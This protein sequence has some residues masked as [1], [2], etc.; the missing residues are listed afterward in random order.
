MDQLHEIRKLVERHG[1]EGPT[2]TAVSGLTLYIETDPAVATYVIYRPVLALI[3][4]GAKRT[5]LGGR[6][7]H[8]SP[9]DYVAVSVDL[10]ATGQVTRAPYSAVTLALDLNVLASLIAE[11]MALPWGATAGFEVNRAGPD[12]LDAML[13]LV[14]LL[15]RPQDIG[16]LALSI[17]REV[18]WRLLQSPSGYMVR[19]IV[20]ADSRLSQ[21]NRAITWLRAN[22]A[23]P[24]RIERLAALAAMSPASFHRHFKAAT[25]MS[26]L[27]YQ[28]QI[29][30]QTAR[31][32]L[33]AQ[34]DDVAGIGFSVGY[35]SPSQFSREYARL[36]GAP[37]GRDAARL[38][39]SL[40]F[41]P[42]RVG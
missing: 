29:R 36:F 19:Q 6:V 15:D 34:P 31:A 42:L 9:G 5:V 24:I 21:V 16:V 1:R 4:G 3:L 28:K 14:R 37:P 25:A 11:P 40:D 7:F 27:E 33:L 20:L 23:A 2:E 10:P 41:D 17:Q 30:L 38:R 32:R 8:V 26:P 18:F 22:F 35:D 39:A 12:L 13:R